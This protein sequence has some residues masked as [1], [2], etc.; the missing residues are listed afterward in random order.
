MEEKNFTNK[1]KELKTLLAIWGQRDLSVI[2]RITIFKS[3]AFSKVIYQCNNITVPDDF[4]KQLIQVAYNFIWQGKPEKVRRKTVIADY[5]HGGLKM[6]DIES[7]LE[8]QKVIWVKRLQRSEEGSWMAYPKYLLNNLLGISSFKCNTNIAKLQKWMPPFYSQLFVAWGKTAADSGDDP[9]KIRREVLWFNKNIQISKKEVF[10]KEWYDKG[11]IIYHDILDERGNIKSVQELSRDYGF[12]VKVMQYNSLVSTIPQNWKR[13]V[14]TMRIP[15]EAISNKEQ[16]YVSCR[17]RILALGITTNKDIYWEFV[18]RKQEQPIVANKWCTEFD[19]PEDEWLC[20]FKTFAELKDTKLKAFQYKI[21][22][23]II[24]C[25]LYL[26]RI[27]RSDVDTC[28][29]C[30][31]LDDQRHYFIECPE[32]QPI[33]LEMLRWW[34]N[35]TTQRITITDR[36]ILIGLEPRNIKVEKVKQLEYIIQTVKWMIYVNKQLGENLTFQKVLG[37]IRGMMQIQ[38]IIA[39]R[40]GRGT[41]YDEE[42]GDVENFLTQN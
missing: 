17:S 35:V 15:S 37:G 6:L 36:D 18:T 20:V 19:I 33:W 2:G 1:L 42:W 3:L 9:F 31:E 38:K 12:E 14:K 23:N 22:N 21:L 34:R 27:G 11:I 4:I 26:K 39:V 30:N 24:P 10:F 7:F 41:T 13:C 40:N 5:E 29:R 25:N 16:L 28:P 8:A 32:T